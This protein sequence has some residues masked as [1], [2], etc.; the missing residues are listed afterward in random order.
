MKRVSRSVRLLNSAAY[1]DPD[2]THPYLLTTIPLQAG[3]S[4]EHDLHVPGCPHLTK[5]T[6]VTEVSGT[7]RELTARPGIWPCRRCQP[8]CRHKVILPDGTDRYRP[9]GPITAGHSQG[10]EYGEYAICEQ[11]QHG[12]WTVREWAA[13]G[14]A[15]LARATELNLVVILGPRDLR[16]GLP[17]PV[18]AH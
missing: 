12:T 11:T 16:H 8:H 4:H 13:D 5:T 1:R 3:K 15:V 18:P 6:P 14:P 9:M 10:E 17:T 2:G 7:Y